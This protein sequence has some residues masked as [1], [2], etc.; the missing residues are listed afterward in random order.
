[1]KKLL[2]IIVICYSCKF[3]NQEIESRNYATCIDSLMKYKKSVERLTLNNSEI[4]F[5]NYNLKDF[6]N[7]KEV[8]LNNVVYTDKKN[9]ISFLLSLKSLE[10]LKIDDS[11]FFEEICTLEIKELSIVYK[12]EVRWHDCLDNLSTLA[13]LSLIGEKLEP[14]V[15]INSPFLKSLILSVDSL[16]A[17][18]EF[19]YK[20]KNLERL[21]LSNTNL[22]FVSA[23]ISNLKNLKSI[24]VSTTPYEMSEWNH[25]KADRNYFLFKDIRENCKDCF[26]YTNIHNY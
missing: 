4:P 9:F 12:S 10:K 25:F 3:S 22:K 18:P 19:V 1:M 13:T 23:E 24:S 6:E 17:I 11:D 26:I 14:E 15:N 7:L 20:L 2:F 5:L 21:N 16:V 8:N